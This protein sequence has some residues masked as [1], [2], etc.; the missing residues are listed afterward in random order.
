MK[1]NIGIYPGHDR[2]YIEILGNNEYI[3]FFL[4]EQIWKNDHIRKKTLKLITPCSI[5]FFRSVIKRKYNIEIDYRN[6]S[7]LKKCFNQ[8]KD[9]PSKKRI[10]EYIKFLLKRYIKYV[11]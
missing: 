1:R 2:K 7:I 8:L 5:M 10:E 4:L 3:M 9:F 6:L 11:K